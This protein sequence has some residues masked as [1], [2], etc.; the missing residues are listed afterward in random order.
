M[1]S[2]QFYLLVSIGLGVGVMS[3]VID[4][5]TGRIVGLH[6]VILLALAVLTRD[7]WQMWHPPGPIIGD[8][9]INSFAAQLFIAA[10]SLPAVLIGYVGSAIVQRR[11]F[12]RSGSVSRS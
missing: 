6:L 3:R 8:A 5:W 7:W 1:K 12:N 9:E 11:L 2:P 4:T 10:I